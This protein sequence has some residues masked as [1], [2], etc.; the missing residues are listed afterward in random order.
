MEPIVQAVLGALE[1]K[2]AKLRE[3]ALGFQLSDAE[4]EV[5][6]AKAS[7]DEQAERAAETARQ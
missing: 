2:A 5:A 3:A 4:K 1:I 6:R 7:E